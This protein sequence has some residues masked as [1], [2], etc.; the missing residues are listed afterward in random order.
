MH[1]LYMSAVTFI[2]FAVLSGLIGQ[3]QVR[4][5]I[6]QFAHGLSALGVILLLLAVQ[7]ALINV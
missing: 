3:A 1:G 2:W 4:Q 7:I 5:F 6:L